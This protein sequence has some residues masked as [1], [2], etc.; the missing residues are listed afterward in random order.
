MS[1]ELS[2]VFGNWDSHEKVKCFFVYI[3]YGQEVL[4]NNSQ[5]KFLKNL[6]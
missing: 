4:C 6:Y 3:N 5:M 2:L 1:S